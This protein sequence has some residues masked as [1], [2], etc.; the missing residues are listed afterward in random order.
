[1]TGAAV[2]ARLTLLV[3]VEAPA[4]LEVEGGAGRGCRVLCQVT[5]ALDTFDVTAGHVSTVRE[6]RVVGKVVDFLPGYLDLLIEMV[7]N[8][9]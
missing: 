4:H 7:E 9:P 1:M 6:G 8:F 5:V 3:A 2:E